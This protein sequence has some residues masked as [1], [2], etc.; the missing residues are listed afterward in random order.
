MNSRCSVSAK[1]TEWESELEQNTDTG[2][3][4]LDGIKTEFR[5]LDGVSKLESVHSGT[6]LQ[7]FNLNSK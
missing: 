6:M 4:L 1:L 3:F 5:I 7:R 2:F